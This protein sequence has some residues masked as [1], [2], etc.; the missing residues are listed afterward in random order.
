[1][2]M[3]RSSSHSPSDTGGRTFLIISF[4]PFLSF[5]RASL[6]ASG[7][8]ICSQPVCFWS[9]PSASAR[10]RLAAY[11]QILPCLGFDKFPQLLEVPPIQP[12]SISGS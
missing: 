10:A 11:F 2:A 4:Q 6:G 8:P 5:E 12:V 3:S 1:M 7:F 9:G